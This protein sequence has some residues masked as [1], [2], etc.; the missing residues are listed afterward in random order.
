VEEA[1]EGNERQHN[2]LKKYICSA[3]NWLLKKPERLTAFSTLAI[4]F[5]TLVAASVG[6]AQWCELQKQVVE[7]QKS[8]D[9]TINNQSP[10]I[11]LHSVSLLKSNSSEV[12]LLDSKGQDIDADVI[13]KV[14]QL[15]PSGRAYP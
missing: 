3:W 7:L 2:I 4:F 1:D 9:L 11:L 6:I 15:W 5:A 14:S 10:W 13:V 8:Y 12:K